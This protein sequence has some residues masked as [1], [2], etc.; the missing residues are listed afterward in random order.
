M[1]VSQPSLRKA[2]VM[3]EGS[4]LASAGFAP[5]VAESFP[6]MRVG[7]DARWYNNSGVGT[8]VAE[9]LR[10]MAAAPRTFELVVYESPNNPVPRLS[11]R[12]LVRIAVQSPRY[13]IG[14]QW[15][16]RRRAREDNL[17]VFHSPFYAAPI[18]LGC[19]LVVTIHDLIPFLFRISSW[20]K[21]QI[22]KTGYQI[23]TRRAAHVIA[24]SENTAA[25][26]GRI[27]GI[28][29][30]RVTAVPLAARACFQPLAEAGELDRLRRAYGIQPPYIVVSSA[31]NWRTK[32]LASALSALEV[33][34]KAGCKFMTVI[35]GPQSKELNSEK[36][37]PT[38]NACCTGFIPD[39]DVAALFRHAAAY[40]T[41]SL[42]EGFGLPVIEAMA[43]GCAVISSNGGSLAE[44][45]GDGAQVFSPYDV[46]G[47]GGAIVRLLTVS[48]EQSHWK[49]AA[50]RRSQNF[51]WSG[52]AAATMTIYDE[53]AKNFLAAKR[54]VRA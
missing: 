1:A 40:V 25:D 5:V 14:E 24:D 32:N 8:Y 13:S 11:G 17:S 33:A 45:A 54:A 2:L 23:A 34:K 42:Y 52:T 4:K 22:V 51:S 15:E 30:T 31:R 28:P 7:F 3:E 6:E 36:Q 9:L 35:C 29:S 46:T 53:L 39:S 44:V 47:M 18:M 21:Q 26:V 27:L 37:W 50:L 38:L 41:A 43:C 19:P 49:R 12:S 48:E 20:P 10:A 16:L